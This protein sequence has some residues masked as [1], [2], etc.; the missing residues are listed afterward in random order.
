MGASPGCPISGTIQFLEPLP[1]VDVEVAVEKCFLLRIAE[2][3]ECCDFR[4]GLIVDSKPSLCKF[5]FYHTTVRARES[6]GSM[7]GICAREAFY[8]LGTLSS[9]V[10]H[11]LFD[12]KPLEALFVGL[13]RFLLSCNAPGLP[14]L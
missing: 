8:V 14:Q 12:R 13:V 6:V 1:S 10:C 9:A 2:F 4:L 3:T 7:Q 5:Y 11:V